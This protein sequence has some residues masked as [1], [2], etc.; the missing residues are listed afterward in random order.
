MASPTI[1]DDVHLDFCEFTP[2]GDCAD[3][4]V[5]STALPA[6]CPARP[7]DAGHA[8]GD[9]TNEV[10]G[11]PLTC[12]GCEA[13]GDASLERAPS[14]EADGREWWRCMVCETTFTFDPG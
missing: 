14:P 8:G 2:T 13:E 7:A 11:N 1:L 4:E 5:A 10:A 9:A 12:P 6:A 3:C